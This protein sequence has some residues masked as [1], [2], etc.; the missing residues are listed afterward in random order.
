VRVDVV[1]VK[2]DIFSILQLTTVG[3]D[4]GLGGGVTTVAWELLNLVHDFLP[5]GDFTE[6]DVLAIEM[7]RSASGD[8]ELRSIGVRTSI[9]H[10]ELVLFI[11]L[12]GERLILEFLAVD[13][14]T[15]SSVTE[16]EIASL[17][18]ESVNDTVETRA[19]VV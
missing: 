10:G 1:F 8:E 5:G 4:H 18:H 14:F 7:S 15:S 16:G 11:V 2:F 3:N 13:R 19:L 17:K 9:S 6:D 12:N